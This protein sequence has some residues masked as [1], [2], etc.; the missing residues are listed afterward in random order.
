MIEV[1]NACFF[2]VNKFFF[3]YFPMHNHP[4]DHEWPES[5]HLSVYVLYAFLSVNSWPIRLIDR[6]INDD[7]TK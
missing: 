5:T 3:P 1:I 4:A 6:A 2:L 7:N